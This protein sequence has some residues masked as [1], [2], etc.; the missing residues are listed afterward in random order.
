MAQ[1]S[2]EL[3]HVLRFELNYLEQGGFDRDRALLGTESPFLGT[4]ACI[5]FGEPLRP[6]A[7][8]ECLL[9]P[10]VP[11]DKLTEDLPCHYIKLNPAGETVAGFIAN[12]DAH[13]MVAALEEWLRGTIARM[14]E[15][16]AGESS[17]A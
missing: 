2:D 17:E 9:R 13:R 10:F 12:N 5:N 8:H 15:S 6:H 14:E 7:C 16:Q 11:E 4:I 3:L 1:N